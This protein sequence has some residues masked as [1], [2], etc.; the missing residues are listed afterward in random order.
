MISLD[1]Y[2]PAASPEDYSTLYDIADT[3]DTRFQTLQEDT[4]V[5]E[6]E[7]YVCR[8][9]W[10]PDGSI[11]AQVRNFVGLDV[12][13]YYIFMRLNRLKIEIKIYYNYFESIQSLVKDKSYL[14]KLLL[15]GLIFMIYG[16]HCLQ[17]I[18]T[19]I[20]HSMKE[21]FTSF[22]DQK[23]LDLCSYIYINMIVLRRN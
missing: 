11:M 16:S 13:S 2:S 23:E 9:D 3:S 12:M 10:W 8:A 21:I 15:F 1:K 14:K 7:Y 22:G 17:P 18:D 19:L 20:I 6:T 5:V 4:G